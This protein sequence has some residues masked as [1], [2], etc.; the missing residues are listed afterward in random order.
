LRR[1]GIVTVDR[2]IAAPVE[3]REMFHRT[4]ALAVDMEAD[5]VRANVTA[6]LVNVRAISDRADEVLDPRVVELVDELG[7]P[8]PL[9]L[10]AG[11][12]RTPKL[13]PYLTRLGKNSKLA[14]QRLGE[15]VRTIVEAINRSDT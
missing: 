7:R 13:I 11:I 3:K 6:P 15:A 9:A 5:R 4:G 8:K 2:I 14:A 12:L 10:A 1:G